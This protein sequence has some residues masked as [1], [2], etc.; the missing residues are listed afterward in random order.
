[1]TIKEA[2]IKSG[3]S[4][5]ALYKQ[6]REGRALGRY[7]KRDAMGRLVIDARKVKGTGK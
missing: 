4:I 3:L 5:G 1:M 2:A 7:F 6:I